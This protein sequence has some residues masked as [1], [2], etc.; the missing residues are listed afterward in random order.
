MII[1]LFLKA[2]PAGKQVKSTHGVAQIAIG[3]SHCVTFIFTLDFIK[4][5]V[6]PNGL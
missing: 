3:T 1:I 4:I 2:T 5:G 6:M